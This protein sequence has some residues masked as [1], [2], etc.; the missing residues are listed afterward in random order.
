MTRENAIRAYIRATEHSIFGAY[1]NPSWN[2]QKAYTNC[3]RRMLEL[4]GRNGKITSWNTSF[5][6][7]AFI[8]TK[9]EKDFLCYITYAHEYH[10][11]LD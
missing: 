1:K 11:Q 5:F 6:S 4:D 2:K 8:Y 9:D 3:V 10:F 7:Y